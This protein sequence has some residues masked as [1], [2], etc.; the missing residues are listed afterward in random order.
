MLIYSI[1]NAV[2]KTLFQKDGNDM[3]IC[4]LTGIKIYAFRTENA[5]GVKIFPL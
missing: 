1:V 2:L 5:E 3:E 4:L